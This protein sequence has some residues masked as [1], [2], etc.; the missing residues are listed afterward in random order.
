M[1]LTE[2][3]LEAQR[4]QFKDVIEQFG[5]ALCQVQGD[6]AGAGYTYTVG[7]TTYKMPELVWAG[8]QSLETI[9]DAMN[10]LVMGWMRNSPPFTLGSATGHIE[11][12]DGKP[13]TLNVV[14]VA[15]KEKCYQHC[16]WVNDMYGGLA[17]FAQVLWP[18]DQGRYPTEFG[19]NAFE[20]PQERF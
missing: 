2:D 12:F 18:D 10:G 15:N 1:A 13:L 11:D 8:D 17:S 7:L 4:Q 20:Q 9:R 19:Y 16:A 5:F 14:A 3:Q 6:A